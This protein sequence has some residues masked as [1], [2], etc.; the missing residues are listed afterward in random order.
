VSISSITA[1]DPELADLAREALDLPEDAA[2]APAILRRLADP[3]AGRTVV[4]FASRDGSGA[5]LGAALG[6]AGP[7]RPEV[8]HVDLIV[9]RRSARRR[10][11]ARELLAQVESALGTPTV[12]LAGNIPCY[13]WPGID[14][15]YTPAICLAETSGYQRVDT[16]CN[17]TVPL[18]DLP[19]PAD[20]PGF[21]I[22]LATEG[23]LPML[24][25]WIRDTFN[26]GWEWETAQA[27]SQRYAACHFAVRD[28]RPAAFAAFGGLRPS[29]FGPMGT[30]PAARG[31]GLGRELLR[32]CLA[33]Q[34]RLGLVTAQIGWA[35][36]VRF[37]STSVGAYI[38]RVFFMYA[39]TR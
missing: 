3:P 10:G 27:V 38:E 12:R 39:K 20:V 30:D 6:S 14:V 15:R 23:D 7:L 18:D 37:Y 34:H 24:L 35:G 25:P 28:G 9:V 11:I 31:H 1:G 5:L 29:L 17:M 32:R 33:D 13:A 19:E 26:K 21:D 36:P 22:R 2:E 4:G 8:G 16:G